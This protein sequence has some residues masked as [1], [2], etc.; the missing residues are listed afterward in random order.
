MRKVRVAGTESTYRLLTGEVRN[1]FN[2][3]IGGLKVLLELV[4]DVWLATHGP[5]DLVGYGK[6]VEEAIESFGIILV[7]TLKDSYER[8]Y[9]DSRWEILDLYQKNLDGT[10][11][12]FGS[13]QV[14]KEKMKM[15]KE[16]FALYGGNGIVLGSEISPVEI[17]FINSLLNHK[18]DK[19]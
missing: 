6:T 10:V 7:D 15:M 14:P 8:C 4:D 3:D 5:S 19:P 12:K 2:I 16:Q 1:S 17:D 13:L 9:L 18:W 11:S